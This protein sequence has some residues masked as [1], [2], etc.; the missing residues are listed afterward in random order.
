MEGKGGRRGL[1]FEQYEAPAGDLDTGAGPRL[2]VGDLPARDE[3]SSERGG[4]PPRTSSLP[5]PALRVSY[6]RHPERKHTLE[7]VR[8][9]AP[10]LKIDISVSLSRRIS[11]SDGRRYLLRRCRGN[12]W[13]LS[14]LPSF[15]S[16]SFILSLLLH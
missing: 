11:L 15:P 9:V 3:L 6:L 13:S 12:G 4:A 2:P 7:T 8:V 10:P 14:L 1:F 16:C 5:P